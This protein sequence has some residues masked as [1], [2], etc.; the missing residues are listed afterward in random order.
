MHL[1]SLFTEQNYA[2]RHEQHNFR[3]W[4]TQTH[5][6]TMYAHTNERKKWKTEGSTE[7]TQ[8]ENPERRD[9]MT[10]KFKMSIILGSHF[11]PTGLISFLTGSYPSIL[12][13]ISLKSFLNISTR[14]EKSARSS[15]ILVFV[16]WDSTFYN[17][18]AFILCTYGYSISNSSFNESV[19]HFDDMNSK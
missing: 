10:L 9:W 5:P 14:E 3:W 1:R 4:N 18:F 17:I 12:F 6:C 15:E 19:L 2:N 11:K 8:F 7:R 13:W 16:T